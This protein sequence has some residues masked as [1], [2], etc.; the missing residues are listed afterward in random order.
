MAQ[1]FRT[2]GVVGKYDTPNLTRPLERLIALLRGRGLDIVV[3]G[4]SAAFIADAACKVVDVEEVGRYADLVVVIGGDGTLL[5]VA[6]LV[7]PHEVPII[8]VNLGRLG[9]LTDIPVDSME[10]T[11]GA[12]L[13]GAYTAESRTLLLATVI[14]AGRE[15]FR[16]LA[17]ND[18]V[19]AKGAAGSMIEFDVYVDGQFVYNLRS[20]GLI[21]A[22]PTG[23][24]A[25]ALSSGGPILHPELEAITL[26]PISPHT[27]SN[28]PIALSDKCSIDVILVR[29]IDARVNFDVQSCFNFEPNDKVVVTAYERT[30]R[31]LHP[32]GHNYFAMLRE[33][34][35]W[36]AKL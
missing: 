10:E 36:S 31:L 34:L 8:G 35:H 28:R 30:L 16:T 33:K 26:A 32:L 24:T 18:V 1:S 20:D 4:R 7:A 22:T 19:V 25:Y 2:I 6:R 11:L 29:G 9:F 23:S 14:R 5:S 17:L 12:M 13:D 21:I 3:D 15:V 27:L